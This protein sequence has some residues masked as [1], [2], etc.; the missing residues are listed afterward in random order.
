MEPLDHAIEPVRVST[1]SVSAWQWDEWAAD[2]ARLACRSRRRTAALA[3]VAAAVV[4]VAGLAS[5]PQDA[6]V[7]A[8]IYSPVVGWLVWAFG[9]DPLAVRASRSV[10]GRVED[11]VVPELVDRADDNVLWSL[12]TN[13]GAVVTHRSIVLRADRLDAEVHLSASEYDPDDLPPLFI[14]SGGGPG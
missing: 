10:L 2:A 11:V 1:T 7:T 9:K 3:V 8:A 13:G 14:P 5:M 6:W 4:A 12:L